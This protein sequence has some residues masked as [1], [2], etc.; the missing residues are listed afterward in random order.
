[1]SRKKWIYTLTDPETGKVVAQGS[2]KEIEEKGLCSSGYMDSMRRAGRK[3]VCGLQM[4]CERVADP[5]PAPAGFYR[6]TR[7]NII[8]TLYDPDGKLMGK[9]SAQ[10]LVEMGLV[11]SK[12]IP[13]NMYKSG[14]GMKRW[15][16][17]RIER[18]LVEEETVNKKPTVK[19][20]KQVL[21]RVKDPGP[22]D[23]DVHYLEIYN[24]KAR[25]RGKKEL[26]YGYWA[27]AGKPEEPK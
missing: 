20:E 9:G 4:R 24:E 21:H 23:W 22:L 17:G 1:M 13:P 25:K 12:G 18:E 10:Q 5:K 27:A 7:T 6:C 2:G 3:M 15:G 11:G 26:T 14:H 16:V 8:Y 19:K